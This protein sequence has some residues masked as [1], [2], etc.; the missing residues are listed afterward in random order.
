MV[1]REEERGATAVE[2]GLIV[3]L[4]ACLN[5]MNLSTVYGAEGRLDE[6][7]VPLQLAYEG[8][9]LTT[10][11]QKQFFFKTHVESDTVV[12][13][14]SENSTRKLSGFESIL[15]ARNVMI[16]PPPPKRGSSSK[17]SAGV[18]VGVD[19]LGIPP[20]EPPPQPARRLTRIRRTPSAAA[21]GTWEKA[22]R[23]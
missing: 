4:I 2:Y 11:D 5:F 22:K 15:V 21:I 3:L 18:G 20:A 19:V 7:A 14:K 12:S 13:E 1:R 9:F 17:I 10:D 8:G 6:A 16:V 23:R